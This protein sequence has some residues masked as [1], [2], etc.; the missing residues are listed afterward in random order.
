MENFLT[1]FGD[2]RFDLD[3]YSRHSDRLTTRVGRLCNPRRSLNKKFVVESTSHLSEND[4]HGILSCFP[5]T[6]DT[7]TRLTQILRTPTE[8]IAKS[9]TASDRKS[10]RNIQNAMSQCLPLTGATTYTES[11]NTLNA[12]INLYDLPEFD[13]AENRLLKIVQC[14]TAFHEL[15]HALLADVYLRI[16]DNS[17][18]S[19]ILQHRNR[20]MDMTEL[21]QKTREE[22]CSVGGVSLYANSYRDL[23]DDAD[24]LTSTRA[25]CE[26]LCEAVAA[27]FLEYSVHEDSKTA[28]NPLPKGSRL[29]EL[30]KFFLSAEQKD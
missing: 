18:I 2:I 24:P 12:H 27:Y 17:S 26:Q 19:M 28:C 14:Q 30:V 20:T 8:W 6:C 3:V 16:E 11:E 5:S 4:I 1:Q 23:M 25:I 13:F 15:T 7:R 29:H 21:L 22:V 10:T 9:A